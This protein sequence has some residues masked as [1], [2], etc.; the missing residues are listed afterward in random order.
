MNWKTIFKKSNVKN[1]KKNGNKFHFRH[2]NAEDLLVNWEEWAQKGNFSENHQEGIHFQWF[3]I[4][5]NKH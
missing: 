3:D 4:C 1:R 5:I 2:W